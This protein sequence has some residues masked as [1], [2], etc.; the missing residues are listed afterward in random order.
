MN[1]NPNAGS[2]VGNEEKTG[3]REMLDPTREEIL[4][5]PGIAEVLR[6]H[7]GLNVDE[8]ETKIAASFIRLGNDVEI[9]IRLSEISNP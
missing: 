3:R 9:K 5:R 1:D 7:Q 2:W 6:V 8:K 4:N